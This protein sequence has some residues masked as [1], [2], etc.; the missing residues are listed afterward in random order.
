[1]AN[2]HHTGF[3]VSDLDRAVEFYRGGFGCEELLR[4][5]LAGPEVEKAVAVPGAVLR[6]ALLKAG[7]VMIELLEYQAPDG[8]PFSLRNNDTGAA[9]LCFTVEDIDEVFARLV[10]GGAEPLWRPS[11]RAPDGQAV[12]TRFAYLR[13]PDGITVEILE[14]GPR[15]GMAELVA[16]AG[17]AG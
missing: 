13:D 14:P 6:T 9:H 8:Q 17:H 11:E 5:E 7:N 4:G 1:M 2:I 16:E 15:F 3:T 10:A 12:G